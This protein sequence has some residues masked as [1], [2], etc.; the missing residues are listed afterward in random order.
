MSSIPLC[1]ESCFTGALIS[2]QPDLLPDVFC[3]IVRI[4]L[5]MLVLFYI[6]INSTNITPIMI[7][8]RIYE[9]QNLLSLQLVSFVVGLRTYQHPFVETDARLDGRKFHAFQEPR[10]TFDLVDKPI[11]LR[12]IL[13]S[14]NGHLLLISNYI[15]RCSFA[16]CN[17][18]NIYT[19]ECVLTCPSN[20]TL[21]PF[22]VNSTI[23]QP[24][25]C[26]VLN[27]IMAAA[28]RTQMN[29]EI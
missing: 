1:K 28:V 10:N 25:C 26:V 20:Q 18:S 15:I 24:Y 13:K 19:C 7:I 14:R 12:Y 4:F 11:Y 17:R 21:C 2:P 16:K 3:L 8:N 29:T 9:T 22:D 6:Y 27:L 23:I 5:L